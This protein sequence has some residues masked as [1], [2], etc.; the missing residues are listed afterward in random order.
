MRMLIRD[1]V[2]RWALVAVLC[3]GLGIGLAGCGDDDTPTP[4]APTPTPTP[5]VT[6]PAEEPPA[7]EPPAEE[8][9]AEEPPAEEPPAEEA[10]EPPA[11]EAEEPPAE[12]AEE[13]PAEEEEDEAEEE[14]PPPPPSSATIDSFT[15]PTLRFA[16][17]RSVTVSFK[18]TGVETMSLEIEPMKVGAVTV[19]VPLVVAEGQPAPG[20]SPTAG[21]DAEEKSYTGTHMQDDVDVSTTFTLVVTDAMGGKTSESIE[22][23]VIDD[24]AK[25]NSFTKSPPAETSNIVTLSWTTTDATAWVLRASTNPGEVTVSQP[26]TVSGSPQPESGNVAVEPRP[27]TTTY[28]LTATGRN[29]EPVIDTVQVLG[30]DE[31]P[32]AAA[33][34]DFM[35]PFNAVTGGTKLPTVTEGV[36][37]FLRWTT[38]NTTTSVTITADTGGTVTKPSVDNSAEFT[39]NRLGETVY[40]IRANGPGDG[41]VSPIRVSVDVVE[42]SEA[43]ITAFEAVDSGESPDLDAY[44]RDVELTWTVTLA[45]E[46]TLL[47]NGVSISID[48]DLNEDG[49]GM[50]TQMVNPIETTTYQVTATSK[51]QNQKLTESNLIRVIVREAIPPSIGEFTTAVDE[52][53]EPDTS[54]TLVWLNVIAAELTFTASTGGTITLEGATTAGAEV[55]KAVSPFV[56]TDYTLTAIG[57]GDTGSVEDTVTVTV[58]ATP[59]GSFIRTVVQ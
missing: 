57:E 40:T 47:A 36:A 34:L 6:P 32:V 50:F 3:V 23:T 39:L 49:E 7:E 1:L 22:V 26:T 56:T 31:S 13:P 27:L 25:I 38:N 19:T 20:T 44:G 43:T 51:G 10:E 2:P 35:G 9:P 53:F 54:V 33:V 15:T 45:K 4:T 55:R 28:T 46:V 58:E 24:Q 29:G 42:A 59:G 52:P 21:V 30:Q 5:P 8:P 17:A 18:A 14:E 12:E 37:F 11:E 41:G 48:D 16:G